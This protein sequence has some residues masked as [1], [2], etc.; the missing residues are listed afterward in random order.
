MVKE[1]AILA[2]KIVGLSHSNYK[3][4]MFHDESAIY[5]KSNERI[6]DYEKYLQ[7]K[8]NALSVI[9]SSDQIISMISGGTK[10]I[11][12]FDISTFPKYYMYL[13]LAGIMSLNIDEYLNFFYKIDDKAET[14]DDI[15][16]DLIR[17][18]LEKNSQ[19][20]WDSLINF[21]DWND[22]TSSSLFSS[23][24]VSVSGVLEHTNFINK[25][26][27]NKLKKLIPSININTY[28]GNII[29]ISNKF[30]KAYDLIYLS[31]I[32]YYVDRKKYKEVLDRLK[33]T[34]NGLI[35]TY[36]Y[37]SLEQVNRYFKEDNYYIEP[38]KN[39]KAGLLIKKSR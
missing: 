23:E 9:A 26:D 38:I 12:C 11:D 3:N 25:Q 34:N 15:Y 18:N 21:Y 28:E 4:T 29:D 27:F 13:K 14:Y 30:N 35:L 19:E 6:K 7:N 1:D 20:F 24:P 16:F 33:L 36:L 5:I 22:I 2:Q 39:T 17:Q 31:N 32:I 8:K 37:D 10:N